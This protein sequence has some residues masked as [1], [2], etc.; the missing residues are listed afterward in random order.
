MKNRTEDWYWHIRR[1]LGVRDFDYAPE[2][3][4]CIREDLELWPADHTTI[5]RIKRLISPPLHRSIH[6]LAKT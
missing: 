5:A 3:D 4:R 2:V 1:S 6:P